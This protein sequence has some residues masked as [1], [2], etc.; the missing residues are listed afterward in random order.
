VA[1]EQPSR[2]SN[3]GIKMRR[4]LFIMSNGIIT[5]EK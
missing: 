1:A 3:M 5:R 4:I 2:N